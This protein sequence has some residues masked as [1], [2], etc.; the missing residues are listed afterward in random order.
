MFLSHRALVSGVSIA[1]A[2]GAVDTTVVARGP[3]PNSPTA[4]TSRVPQ[5][6]AV[7]YRSI[8]NL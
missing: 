6:R 2:A 4:T 1:I 8:H 5:P 7:R 3:Q